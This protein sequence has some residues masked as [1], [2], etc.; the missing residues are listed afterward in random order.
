MHYS[1]NDIKLHYVYYIPINGIRLL[2]Q[3][4]IPVS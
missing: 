1:Q 3:I 2:M 4:A